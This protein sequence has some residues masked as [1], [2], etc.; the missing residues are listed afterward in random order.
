VQR[1]LVTSAHKQRV[2]D[3]DLRQADMTKTLHKQSV[4]VR[5]VS[6]QKTL[7]AANSWKTVKLV[8]E[9][10]MSCAVNLWKIAKVGSQQKI[11]GGNR[12]NQIALHD[13]VQKT[14]C[15]VVMVMNVPQGLEQKKQGVKVSKQT[16]QLA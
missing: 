3:W 15:M 6:E 7:C 16:K 9:Q 14:L 2:K 12:Q 11:F 10:K 13:L 4:I 1:R 8:L 5:L